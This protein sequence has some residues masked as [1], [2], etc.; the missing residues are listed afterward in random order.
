MEE[1]DW[2][3]L[4]DRRKIARLAV[5][6]KAHDGHLSIPVRNLQHPVT[7]P[8]R[9]THNKSYIEIRANKDTF[10]YSFLPRTLTE[11][12]SLPSTLVNMEEPK[13]IKAQLQKYFQ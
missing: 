11:W 1:L 4:A 10:K 13:E 3:T 6:H 7:R 12:N 9:R 8:T 2:R 5:F